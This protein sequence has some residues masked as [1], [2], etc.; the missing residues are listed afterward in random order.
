MTNE[1][2][3]DLIGRA[4]A[5]GEVD[6]LAAHLAPECEYISEYSF[7][8]CQTADAIIE[9]LEKVY[10]KSKDKC[11]YT[12]KIVSLQDILRD[13]KFEDFKHHPGLSVLEHGFLLYHYSKTY[14]AAVVVTM[15]D[16]KGRLNNI[17]LSRNS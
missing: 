3:M 14:P 15:H 6:A 16:N 2:L 12:Y 13:R 17:L 1:Q 11:R 5:F 9:R 8:K 7:F 4:F 10:F